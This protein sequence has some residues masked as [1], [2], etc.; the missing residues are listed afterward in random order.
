MQDGARV[1]NVNLIK[2]LTS[3]GVKI[4]IVAVA[5][6]SENCDIEEIRKVCGVSECF[7]IRRRENGGRFGLKG[8]LG[9]LK[10]FL[11]RPWLA[12]TL[13]PFAQAG[14]SREISRALRKGLQECGGAAIVY[15]G[16]HT[17]AHSSAMGKYRRPKAIAQVFYRAHNVESEIWKRKA[18]QTRFFPLRLFLTFQTFLMKR[19]EES[20]VRG[21]NSVMTVSEV[22]LELFKKGVPSIRGGSVPIGY[23][24]GSNP[25][26]PPNEKS[27]D[28]LLFLGRLDW[29]PNRDGLLWFLDQVWP[30]VHRR[31]PSLQ[32]W[33]AGSGNAEWLKSRKDMPGVQFLGRVPSVDDIYRDSL[34]SIVPIFYGSGTRVKAIEASRYGR[35]CLSTAIGIEG[36]GL[37][38]GR[39]YLHA[40]TANEWIELL[41]NLNP[42]EAIEVGMRAHEA[43]KRSFHLPVAAQRFLDLRG[44]DH[45][46]KGRAPF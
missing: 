44:G 17:A 46:P 1:A 7:V 31:R 8:A 35:A 27:R 41:G 22:D 20:L 12:V 33:I 24:F 6:E 34:L 18:A 38:A 11:H 15:D 13:M 30:E 2:G 42:R 9:V 40:E 23:D 32:L 5:G 37:E 43:L 26:T 36:L 10:S 39:S 3:L 29:P 19:F 45:L 25:P 28:R 4:D 21:A 14:V 16:L